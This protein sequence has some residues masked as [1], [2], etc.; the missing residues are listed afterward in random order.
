[1]PWV[2]DVGDADLEPRPFDLESRMLGENGG[3]I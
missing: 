3:A 1:M 2:R